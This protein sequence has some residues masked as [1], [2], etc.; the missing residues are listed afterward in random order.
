[1]FIWTK[2]KILCVV[3]TLVCEFFMILKHHKKF[4]ILL[5]CET[6]S[7]FHD[8]NWTH[9]S[10]NTIKKV[11][12]THAIMAD[13]EYAF[14]ILLTSPSKSAGQPHTTRLR[15]TFDTILY[16][17]IAGCQS[18]IVPIDL[19]PVWTQRDRFYTWRIKKLG[20][21]DKP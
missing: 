1:M 15:Q 3:P 9:P 17:K 19:S 21:W 5:I 8:L 14:R 2:T 12:N 7:I 20:W 18:R 16:I 4:K 11:I 6:K 10:A 13:V